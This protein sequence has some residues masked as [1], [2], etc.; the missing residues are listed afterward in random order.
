MFILSV[1][2]SRKIRD[3]GSWI[4]NEIRHDVILSAAK[5]LLRHH[6]TPLYGVRLIHHFVVPLPQRGKVFRAPS[7][8]SELWEG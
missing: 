8:L 2:S 1:K 6:R 3:R 4:K 5:D 7:T